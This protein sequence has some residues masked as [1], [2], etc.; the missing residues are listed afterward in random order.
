M[1]VCS[2]S[3]RSSASWWSCRNGRSASDI[4]PDVS[5]VLTSSL[6][7][8]C[9]R[10]T[11]PRCSCSQST[12]RRCS[13]ALSSC[14]CSC[15]ARLCR[16]EGALVF[17]RA[18]GDVPRGPLLTISM[19]DGSWAWQRVAGCA[20]WRSAASA[21][22]WPCQLGCSAFDVL[23]DVSQMLTSRWCS[24]CL[25]LPPQTAHAAEAR[26]ARARGLCRLAGAHAV[27]G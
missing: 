8:R 26:L 9:P 24:R 4:S 21:L 18:P 27:L 14:R 17:G 12:S 3:A 5:Q 2:S 25:C 19:R 23:P 11:L 13:W 1:W 7:S 10:F 6:C 16:L 20:A 22:A 15:R